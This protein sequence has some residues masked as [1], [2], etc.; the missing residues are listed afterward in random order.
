M[1]ISVWRRHALTVAYGAFS[2]KIN[3]VTIFKE[4]LNPEGH[5]NCNTGSKVMAVLLNG[6]ALPINGASLGQVCAYSLRRR[7]VF[8]YPFWITLYACLLYKPGWH[9]ETW[10]GELFIVWSIPRNFASHFHSVPFSSKLYRAY[11]GALASTI[12]G[13]RLPNY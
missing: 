5:I 3:Y 13:L 6:W 2:H 8:F 10:A 1:K 12:F 4:I 11:F 7:L 9:Y